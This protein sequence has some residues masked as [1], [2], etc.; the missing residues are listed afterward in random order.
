M[1][2]TDKADAPAPV[3]FDLDAVVTR[4]TSDYLLLHPV[5]AAPTGVVITL[6]GP[7]H[8]DRKRLIHAALLHHR[9]EYER[10]GKVGLAPDEAEAQAVAMVIGCT[11]GWSGFTVGGEPLAFSAAA[12]TALFNDPRRAWVRDQVKAAL[13]RRDLFIGSSANN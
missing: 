11:L 8:P 2:P 13:D 9:D 4:A 6:A 3:A 5:T 1:K 10:T 7:E 12:C